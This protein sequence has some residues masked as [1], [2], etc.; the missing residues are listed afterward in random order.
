MKIALLN[1]RS[2]NYIEGDEDIRKMTQQ[3]RILDSHLSI[4]LDLPGAGYLS[5]NLF[6]MVTSPVLGK[7][8][9]QR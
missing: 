2:Y 4:S 1:E 3:T 8:L 7:W 5:E 9:H 6:L